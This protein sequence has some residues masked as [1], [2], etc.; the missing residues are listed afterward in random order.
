MSNKPSTM[1]AVFLALELLRRIPRTRSVT[2]KELW[3]E[4]TAAGLQREL[5][6]IQR[7]LD[8][9]T[10]HFDIDRDERSK[11]YGYRWKSGAN[12]LSL[13]GLTAEQ[14]LILQ[15]AEQQLS[16]MLPASVKK[17]MNGYFEQ[18]KDNLRPHTSALRER[19]WLRKVI[20]VS[21]TQPMLPP[22]IQ[23][24]VFEV[25]SQALYRDEW[26][27]ID[28]TNAG[29]SRR[30]DSIMP[31]GM[32]QQGVRLYLVCMY[33]GFDDVRYIALHRFHGAALTGLPFE[34]P[35]DF[36]LTAYAESGNFGV[37]AGP[38]I[39][40]KMV[41]NQE[42]SKYLLE[43]PLSDDQTAVREGRD[44]VITATVAKTELLGRWLRG[45]GAALKSVE[46]SDLLL[47]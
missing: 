24:D 35:A 7:Q 36:D 38:D 10:R 39:K 47:L 12:A 5:R 40:L 2:A 11:P 14:S 32:V 31:L 37:V 3:Q 6:T 19:E 18:A 23:P 17:S 28:Y 26:L 4:L 43:T 20:V 33:R 15:L 44:Y 21:A 1:E 46:P 27:E 41:V 13:V 9:L 30:K 42:A 29:G 34:R 45:F 8:E 22:S 16:P 25:V